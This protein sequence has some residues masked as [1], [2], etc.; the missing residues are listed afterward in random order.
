V[1]NRVRAFVVWDCDGSISKSRPAVKST[2]RPALRYQR[3]YGAQDRHGVGR[4]SPLHVHVGEDEP[5]RL[6]M[7][8]C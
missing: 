3:N 8:S 5:H 7:V 4:P 1:V 6:V 2:S